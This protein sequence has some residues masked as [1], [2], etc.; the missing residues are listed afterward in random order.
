MQ[1]KKF[2]GIN[3]NNYRIKMP[4]SY[5]MNGFRHEVIY[6]SNIYKKGSFANIRKIIE[7]DKITIT[8]L[9]GVNG[10]ISRQEFAKNM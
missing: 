10:V 1:S 7:E 5:K 8:D 6:E 2:S 4:E 3:I 9:I